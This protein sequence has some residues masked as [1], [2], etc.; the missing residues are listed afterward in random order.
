MYIR[1]VLKPFIRFSLSE[2]PLLHKSSILS[3][4]A[5]F[6]NMAPDKSVSGRI[7]CAGIFSVKTRRRWQ[8]LRYNEVRTKSMLRN[9]LSK[10]LS[11]VPKKKKKKEYFYKLYAGFFE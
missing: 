1:R 8:K 3:E 2:S 9:R 4:V 11:F 10:D 7:C 6:P 5:I